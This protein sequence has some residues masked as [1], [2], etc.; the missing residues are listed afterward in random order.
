MGQCLRALP[1]FSLWNNT[2]GYLSYYIADTGLMAR[3]PCDGTRPAGSIFPLQWP[4][5]SRY[6]GSCWF[7]W[8]CFLDHVDG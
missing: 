4:G 1:S 2:A 7:R 3:G 8:N 5:S 6:N